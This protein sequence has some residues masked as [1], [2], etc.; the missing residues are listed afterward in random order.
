PLVLHPEGL[1]EAEPGHAGSSP[2]LAC[3]ITHPFW[4]NHMML[5]PTADNRGGLRFGSLAAVYYGVQGLVGVA[6][7]K[8]DLQNTVAAGLTSGCLFGAVYLPARGGGRLRSSILGAALGAVVAF[9][10]GYVQHQLD[11]LVEGNMSPTES[12]TTAAEAAL[13]QESTPRR[14]PRQPPGTTD[15]VIAQLE[16][17]MNSRQDPGTHKPA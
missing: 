1:M 14:I 6:R 5:T 12:Q 3:L 16:G 7:A 13:Q 9:P 11:T 4:C 2:M 15:S 8:E 10:V 17:S